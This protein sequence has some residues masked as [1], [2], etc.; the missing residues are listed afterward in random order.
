M[1]RSVT[2]AVVSEDAAGRQ[3]AGHARKVL[4]AVPYED[5]NAVTI[6]TYDLGSWGSSTSLDPPRELAGELARC[7]AIVATSSG[8][9]SLPAHGRLGRLI[10]EFGQHIHVRHVRRLPGVLSPLAGQPEVDF[11]VVR[12]VGEGNYGGRG[13]ALWTGTPQEIAS[14]VAVQTA[15]CVD[16]VVAYAFRRA[17][18]RPRGKLTLVHKSNILVHAAHVWNR[19]VSRIAPE[20]PSVRVE[21]LHVDA[22]AMFVVS[23]PERFDVVVT[24]G[25]F[26]DVMIGLGGAVSGGGP[27]AGGHIA[28][29]AGVPSL[30]RPSGP[31]GVTG[32]PDVRAVALAAALALEH[33]GRAAEAARV[34]A[35][36]LNDLDEH[37][38]RSGRSP[39]AVGDELALRVSLD[40]P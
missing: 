3:A 18:A 23:Q 32:G 34:E 1:T 33:A 37:G 8:D 4:D 31:P 21:Y 15:R 2:L 19:A 11:V 24:D 16:A 30:F 20:F 5:G 38:T 6:R 13:A 39:A 25:L 22:A 9:G 28:V 17:A 36:V 26:G 12:D 14:E 27:A 10:E 7:D 35:A 40:G 29:E